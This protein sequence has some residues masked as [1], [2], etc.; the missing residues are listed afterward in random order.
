VQG[1]TAVVRGTLPTPSQREI[2]LRLWVGA[3]QVVRTRRTI[4]AD[5]LFKRSEDRQCGAPQ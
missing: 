2:P 3:K 4:Q 5:M 1:A